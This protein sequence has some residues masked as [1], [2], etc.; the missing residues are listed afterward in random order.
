MLKWVA[1]FFME[2]LG[3]ERVNINRSKEAI[4]TGA[5]TVISE[6][7]FCAVMLG[8]GIAAIEEDGMHKPIVKD[9][10]VLLKDAL[11]S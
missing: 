6:C 8:D 7:P 4:Q 10:A 11:E 2:E 3:D 1:Q 9:L 5:S